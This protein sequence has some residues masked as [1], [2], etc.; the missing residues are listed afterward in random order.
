M[1]KKQRYGLSDKDMYVED[2]TF[3]YLYNIYKKNKFGKKIIFFLFK[4]LYT[5]LFLKNQF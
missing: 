2:N 4:D 1:L 5:L 3:S